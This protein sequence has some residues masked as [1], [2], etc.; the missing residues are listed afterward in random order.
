MTDSIQNALIFEIGEMIVE[1]PRYA[2]DAWHSISLVATIGEDVE[3]LT[4]FRF[5][6][7]GQSSPGTPRRGGAILDKL[8][9]LREQ[10]QQTGGGAFVQCLIQI[11]KPDYDLT[12]K[13]EHDDPERWSP[14]SVSMDMSAFA[15]ALRPA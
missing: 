13:F 5:D 3:E 10:M 14:G 11:K 4:A 1:D 9:E 7:A 6:E 15:D 8:I 2:D 12:V